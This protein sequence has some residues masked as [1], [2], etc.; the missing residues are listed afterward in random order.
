MVKISKNKVYLSTYHRVL[1]FIWWLK[2][3]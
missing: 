2:N 1:Y 3:L